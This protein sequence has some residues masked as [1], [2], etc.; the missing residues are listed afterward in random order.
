VVERFKGE[1]TFGH[2]TMKDV[3]RSKIAELATK[4]LKPRERR[5]RLEPLRTGGDGTSRRAYC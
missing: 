2:L 3:V 5:A 1:P 4:L